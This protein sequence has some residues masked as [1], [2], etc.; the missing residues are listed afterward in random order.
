MQHDRDRINPLARSSPANGCLRPARNDP[1]PRP[2][3]EERGTPVH[4]RGARHPDDPLP[5]PGEPLG[6]GI[7]PRC[8][9]LPA[10]QL[11]PG[12][13][14][15]DRPPAP[16]STTC[17]GPGA[18]GSTPT[19]QGGAPSSTESPMLHPTACPR[20]VRAVRRPRTLLTAPTLREPPTHSMAGPGTASRAAGALMLL[21][22]SRRPRCSSRRWTAPRGAA[23]SPGG[24]D[25]V[26]IAASGNRG[27]V[28]ATGTI[29]CPIAVTPTTPFPTL[30]PCSRLLTMNIRH[31]PQ[32]HL[33]VP[34]RR[35]DLSV[36]A[37]AAPRQPSP[38]RHE[39][40]PFW[41]NIGER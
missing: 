28:R 10:R 16:A 39:A 11:A 32:Q 27:D 12:S 17:P 7:P 23:R 29:A 33:P 40:A 22:R 19:P 26:T 31:L 13:H 15:T 35:A 41:G 38:K 8:S 1:T 21:R 5:R 3:P 20:L 25:P 37:P 6:V 24:R 34:D 36:P 9:G 4:G 14:F 2:P 30:P 18:R